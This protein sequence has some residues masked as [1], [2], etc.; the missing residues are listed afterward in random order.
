MQLDFTGYHTIR[1]Y[2]QRERETEGDRG[3]RRESR[4]C[5]CAEGLPEYGP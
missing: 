5:R 3:R 2:L 1:R 4:L